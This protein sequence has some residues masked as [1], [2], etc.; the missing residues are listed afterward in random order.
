VWHTVK[1]S[2]PSLAERLAV[3]REAVSRR[4]SPTRDGA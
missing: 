2:L 1:L 4:G 3:I